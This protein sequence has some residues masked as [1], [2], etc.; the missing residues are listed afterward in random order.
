MV[1]FFDVMDRNKHSLL[2]RKL[3]SKSDH[4]RELL[5]VPILHAK[6]DMGSLGSHLPK[7]DGYVSVVSKFWQ[8]IEE[9]VKRYVNGFQR[10]KVY[11]D[12]LPNTEKKLVDRIINEVE[13]PNYQLLRFLKDKG[14]KI[15]GTE[16]PNLLRQEYTF[17]S[18]IVQA[19][20]SEDR[21]K[22]REIYGKLA[23]SILTKRDAYIAKRIGETLKLGDVGVL[24]IGAA[25]EI[26]SKLPEDIQVE[27]L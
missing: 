21:N 5:I 22:K 19:E 2:S 20:D 3:E 7:E 8:E 6:E 11:Q 16:D 9:R 25:H 18:Q 10:V 17:I 12:G 24:F 27:I 14:A 15:L 26:E 23:E 4:Q 1:G 13:S